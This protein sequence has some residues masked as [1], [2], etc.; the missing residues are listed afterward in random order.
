MLPYDPAIDPTLTPTMPDEA[1]PYVTSPAA[2]FPRQPYELELWFHLAASYELLIAA[3]Y[4]RHSHKR[5]GLKLPYKLDSGL[6]PSPELHAAL[7]TAGQEWVRR[8]VFSSVADRM[9]D[10]IRFANDDEA[11]AW[12]H[13]WL[14]VFKGSPIH[15]RNWGGNTL[16]LLL[17]V[18]RGVLEWVGRLYSHFLRRTDELGSHD[19]RLV[20]NIDSGFHFCPRLATNTRHKPTRIYKMYNRDYFPNIFRLDER[21]TYL[22]DVFVYGTLDPDRAHPTTH[23]E[24]MANVSPHDQLATQGDVAL[25][26]SANSHTVSHDA[27][28][29][30]L[31]TRARDDPGA[32]REEAILNAMRPGDGIYPGTDLTEA[33]GVKVLRSGGRVTKD[34]TQ[35]PLWVGPPRRADLASGAILA[36]PANLVHGFPFYT[37][38]TATFH[39]AKRLSYAS[40]FQPFNELFHPKR[41]LWAYCWGAS[42]N[43][44]S[45]TTTK[46]TRTQTDDEDEVLHRV[47]ADVSHHAK[48]GAAVNKAYTNNN[49]F[50]FM[51]TNVPDVRMF[52][53]LPV[54]L[55][56]ALQLRF[57][58]V[59]P[60]TASALDLAKDLIRRKQ[61]WQA[62][63]PDHESTRMVRTL[64]HMLDYKQ[65]AGSGGVGRAAEE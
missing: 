6:M 14:V 41:R 26:Y 3:G 33:L 58:D 62:P 8:W 17:G 18:E 27:R 52:F 59:F 2:L 63:V 46:G 43:G 42:N 53:S 65:P 32:V 30:A 49:G 31:A 9:E 16:G 25:M 12:A 35:S 55:A 13:S 20:M 37:G 7:I 23:L 51:F 5:L 28:V 15:Y 11:Q 22:P 39:L 45:S 36:W 44:S 10:V 54:Q 57:P 4:P 24:F 60:P 19:G 64:W 29:I 38:R 34:A 48:Q 47:S 40:S 61:E 1:I 50:Y 21:L 56:R